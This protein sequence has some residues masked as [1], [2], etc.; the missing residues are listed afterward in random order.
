[1]PLS[2]RF[3]EVMKM[4][5]IQSTFLVPLAIVGGALAENEYIKALFYLL[6]VAILVLIHM[7]LSAIIGHKRSTQKGFPYSYSA[8]CDAFSFWPNSNYTAPAWS[9]SLLSFTFSY[10]AWPMFANDH[11]RP[12][13][14]GFFGA[15]ILLDA[16]VKWKTLNCYAHGAAGL[17]DVLLGLAFGGFLGIIWWFIVSLLGK[18][19]VFFSEP[20]S[21]RLKCD[22]PKKKHMKCTVYKNGVKTG[23]IFK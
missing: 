10:L 3:S 11:Q 23:S 20:G 7:P 8:A 14:L 16:L 17:V 4:A 12:L 22:K 2:M 15:F 1:M 13:L 9:T 21:N 18:N 6:G 19:F 5:A